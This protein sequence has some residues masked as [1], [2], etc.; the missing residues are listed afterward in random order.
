MKIV[1]ILTG[2]ASATFTKK[3]QGN[4]VS[5]YYKGSPHYLENPV[6]HLATMSYYSVVVT[7]LVNNNPE[8]LPDHNKC[9]KS[10]SLLYF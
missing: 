2:S 8:N 10:M 6:Y 5:C 3:K 9:K 7:I 1:S 4:S